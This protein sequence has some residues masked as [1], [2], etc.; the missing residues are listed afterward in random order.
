MTDPESAIH[1]FRTG[2][3]NSDPIVVAGVRA[4]RDA[5]TETRLAAMLTPE[6]IEIVAG[7]AAAAAI[8]ATWNPVS[9]RVLRGV[10]E[11]PL[12]ELRDTPGATIADIL[13]VLRAT[14]DQL[15]PNQENPA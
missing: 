12:A 8:G 6:M 1:N 4:A 7:I 11:G 13:L 15:E 3:D 9:A 14:A 5:L 2:V 10:A